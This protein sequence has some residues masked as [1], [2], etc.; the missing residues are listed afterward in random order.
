[1]QWKRIEDKAL[2]LDS[3]LAMFRIQSPSALVKNDPLLL[4]K[5]DPL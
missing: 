1:M 4:S 5:T 2:Q 3:A